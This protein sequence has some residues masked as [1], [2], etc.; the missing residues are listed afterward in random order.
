VR[1]RMPFGPLGTLI[2]A[3]FVRRQ[4]NAIFEFRNKKLVELITPERLADTR[5][6]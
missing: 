4:L 6:T 2:H 1:Y 5:A 3:M